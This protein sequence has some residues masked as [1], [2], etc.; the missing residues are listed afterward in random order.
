MSWLY[1]LDEQGQPVHVDDEA[2][3]EVWW[4]WYKD[5]NE[6]RR[7]AWTNMGDAWVAT[8][9]E[10]IDRTHGVG[11]TPVLWETRASV[12]G[13]IAEFAG[14]IETYTSREAAVAG[15]ERMVERV[16]AALAVSNG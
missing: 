12:P 10:G 5:D 13:K 1:I 2:D 15:H 11:D 14:A 3:E 9:F 6:R 16:K 8:F 7:I 4:T